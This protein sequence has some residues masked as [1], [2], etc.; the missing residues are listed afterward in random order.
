MRSSTNSKFI[1]AAMVLGSFAVAACQTDDA[2]DQ[3]ASAI[4]ASGG[5]GRVHVDS[6]AGDVARDSGTIGVTGR[7]L[8]DANVL[9]LLTTMNAKQIAAADIELQAWRSDTVRAFAASIAR[10]QAAL[11]HSVDSLAGRLHLAPV[12]P[13]LAGTLTTTM[14]ASI[15]SLQQVRGAPLD[16]AFIRQQLSAQ[17]LMSSY[18][19]QLAAVAEEPDVQALSASAAA[20]VRAQLT[21]AQ[22]LN[23]MFSRAD[24]LGA[25]G[26]ADSAAKR[27]ARHTH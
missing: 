26:S 22:A 14:Q 23:G 9:S 21:R 5:T 13:A 2:G 17:S 12:A 8:T 24:S 7:W 16:R 18:A 25:A 19:E 4:V 10:D 3:P 15:D 20:Q 6:A 1:L 11:Q 27:A